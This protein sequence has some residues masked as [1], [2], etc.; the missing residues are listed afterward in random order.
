MTAT[1]VTFLA[2]GI[3]GG[4]V[5]AAAGG[6]KLFVFPLL[7]ATGLPPLAANVTQ[8]V[9]LWPAQLPAIWVYRRE[10][11]GQWRSLFRQ[12][13]PALAGGLLGALVLVNSG[14]DAFV[15]VVPFLLA[16]AVAAIILGPRT[17][18]VLHKLFPGH[19]IKPAT[20]ALFAA[21]GFYCGYFGAGMGFMLLAVLTASTGQSVSQVNGAK[22]LF[23]VFIQTV[24]VVPMM[25]SGLVDWTAAIFVLA[26]GLVGGFIGAA[27]TRRLPDSLVRYGVALIG[28]VLTLAFL[29]A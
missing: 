25:M 22:N 26:G 5:N 10:L 2:A 4:I 20:A 12:M 7:L 13:L 1:I 23:A 6:A 29:F 14:N 16:I 24:A 19:R 17:A 9:A 21:I 11:M 8:G 28:L 27:V 18:L 15:R 3:L